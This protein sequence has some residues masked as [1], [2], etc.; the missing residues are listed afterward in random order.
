[1]ALSSGQLSTA[2][3]QAFLNAVFRTGSYTA[4][5]HIYV[6]LSSTAPTDATGS[7]LTEPPIGTNGYA[8]AQLDPG[9]GNWAAASASGTGQ[10]TSNSSAITFPT[11]TGSWS[12]GATMIWFS[13]WDAST[14]GNLIGLGTLTTGQAVGA[15]GI[16]L[17]F[18]SGQLVP[19]LT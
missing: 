4:P 6:G 2:Q 5:V 18:S 10:G 14:S 12:S 3:E 17:S 7:G 15:S 13:L 11:S 8:R 16:T 1:M 19:T 9:T